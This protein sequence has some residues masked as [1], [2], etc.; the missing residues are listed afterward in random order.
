MVKTGN[1]IKSI[2]KAASVLKSF[3]PDEL[4]LSPAEIALQV[5]IPTPTAYRILATLA[6]LK[7][8]QQDPKTGKYSVGPSLYMLGSLYLA[9][10]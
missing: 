9:L 3:T 2:V 4:E 1:Y 8:L 7:L 6:H 5:K 10:S